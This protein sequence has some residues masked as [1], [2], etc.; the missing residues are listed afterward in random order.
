MCANV[1]IKSI[2]RFIA[3]AFLS[4]IK[5]PVHMYTRVHTHTPILTNYPVKS[6]K[7]FDAKRM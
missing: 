1:I 4:P 3:I 5:M 2:G 7:G 6:I